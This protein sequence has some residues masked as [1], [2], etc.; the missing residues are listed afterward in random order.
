MSLGTTQFEWIKCKTDK[1]YLD[2]KYD[3]VLTASLEVLAELEG[4][5]K[6][7]KR[8]MEWADLAARC[9][10]KTGA[11]VQARKWASI[12]AAMDHIHDLQAP[13][14]PLFLNIRFVTYP[15]AYPITF[16]IQNSHEN[17]NNNTH[18]CSLPPPAPFCFRPLQGRRLLASV[19]V[20]Q[21]NDLEAAANFQVL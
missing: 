7:S 14:P 1:L 16:Q 8:R 6:Q 12:R 15:L 4:D 3:Q 13:L 2:G 19:L 17:F 10:L 9:A 5:E 11:L 21:G 20:A 18:S